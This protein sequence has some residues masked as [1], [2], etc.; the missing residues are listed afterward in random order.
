MDIV[1]YGG[2]TNS[3]AMIIGLINHGIIPDLI[4]FS[5]TGGERPDT[6]AFI[7]MFSDWLEEHGAPRVKRLQYTTKDGAVQTLEE[8]CLKRDTLPAIA[9]G[10]KS[11]SQKYKTRVT[12]KF[13]NNNPECKAI[14]KNGEK[15]NKYIGYDAGEEKRVNCHKAYDATDKKY[16]NLYPLFDWGWTRDICVKVIQEAGLPLPG[17]S[18]CFFCPSMKKAEIEAL[19]NTYPE[20]FE[21]AIEMERRAKPNLDTVKG[22]GRQWSWEDYYNKKI[23]EPEQLSIFDFEEQNISCGCLVPCGCFD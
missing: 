21:R 1:T 6:Y 13:C 10:F 7:E 20:L 19:W 14:W 11:C 5:D 22:L 16:N 15:I 17:K 12:E 9:F 18:S 8:D 2:G 23:N 4:L 3:T